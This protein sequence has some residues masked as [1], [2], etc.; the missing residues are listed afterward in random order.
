MTSEE[1]AANAIKNDEMMA[2]AHDPYRMDDGG[3]VCRKCGGRFGLL[4]LSRLA[5]V[6]PIDLDDD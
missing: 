1:D 3:I 4:L 6:Y 5:P 2:C